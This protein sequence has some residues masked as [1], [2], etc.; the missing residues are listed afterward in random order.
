MFIKLALV[1]LVCVFLA[2]VGVLQVAAVFNKLHGLLFFPKKLFSYFFAI[3]IIGVA[4]SVLFAWNWHYGIGI[5]E[6]AQQAGLFFLAMGFALLF[7]LLVSSFINRRRFS[8]PNDNLE[9]LDAL[10]NRTFIHA[11]KSRFRKQ[12]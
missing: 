9:G 1:Y 4:L 3:A 8:A 10:R 11:I 2:G 5:I 6:G 7:T 12:D